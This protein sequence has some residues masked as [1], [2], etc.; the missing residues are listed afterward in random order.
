MTTPKKKAS[1]RPWTGDRTKD[2][3]K[4][5]DELTESEEEKRIADLNEKRLKAKEAA[6]NRF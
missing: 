3:L 5:F 6:K 4:A 2:V 1:S